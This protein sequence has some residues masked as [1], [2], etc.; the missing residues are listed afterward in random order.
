[1]SYQRHWSALTPMSILSLTCIVAACI[2]TMVSASKQDPANLI[3]NNVPIKWV[4]FNTNSTLSEVIGGIT[5]T[6]FA[7]GGNMAVF[8]FLPEMKRPEDFKKSVALMQAVQLVIYSIVGAV[9]YR[10]VPLPLIFLTF[11]SFFAPF[12]AFLPCFLLPL[13][14]GS[15]QY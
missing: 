13:P 3:V 12:A 11:S 1:M 5:N 14:S 9:L 15:H 2:I 10:S 4:S 8:S 7:Y 6:I